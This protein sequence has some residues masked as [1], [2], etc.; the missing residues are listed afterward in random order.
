M[1]ATITI[2]DYHKEI[3]NEIV[4]R[5]EQSVGAQIHPPKDKEL[6]AKSN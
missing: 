2:E 3:I 1:D 4:S 5:A 6:E